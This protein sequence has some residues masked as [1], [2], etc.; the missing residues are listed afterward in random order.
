MFELNKIYCM[1][2]LK[3][4]KQMDTESVDLI[5]TDP[6]YGINY[7]SNYSKNRD[8]KEQVADTTQWDNF[9]LIED[10]IKE[11]LRILKN[12]SYLYLFMRWDRLWDMPKPSRLLIWNKGDYGMGDLDDWSPSYEVILV[13]KKGNPF[14][15]GK[16]RRDV[17][18]AFKVANFK[19]R[20]N[21]SPHTK[22]YH[23]TEKPIDL[24]RQLISPSCAIRALVCDPFMGSGTTAVASKQLGKN[25]IGFEINPSYIEIAEKRLKQETIPHII[26]EE[27]W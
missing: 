14:L 27:G 15:R 16:R 8:Y 1:D 7:K 9:I 5:V 23:P 13:F 11:M 24:I 20:A 18:D 25:F 22:M 2:C 12:D 10:H 17:L 4:M 26:N 6:P 3:G 19:S 21:T